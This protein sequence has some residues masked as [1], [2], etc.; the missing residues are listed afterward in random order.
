MSL[1]PTEQQAVQ[2]ITK[3]AIV[4]KVEKPLTVE[5][6]IKKN[7]YKCSE[8]E[9]IRADNARCLPKQVQ[10]VETTTP[11]QTAVKTPQISSEGNSYEPGQCVWYIKNLRPEIPNNWGNASSW[12]YNAQAQG[13]PTGSAP[14]VG[15]VG[16]TSGHVVL[17][18]AVNGSQVSYT[19]MNG[20][21]IPFEI[22]S[23]TRDSSFYQYI[24]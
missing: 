1:A 17:I 20:N 5:E 4:K 8:S 2:I 6:K 24:Y 16:W 12:L 9:W 3:P 7:F 15:A 14:R 10:T 13:W 18:T 19:D 21:W 11:T 23:G 22:G